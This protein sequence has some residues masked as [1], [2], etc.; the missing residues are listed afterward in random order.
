MK[1][2]FYSTYGDTLVIVSKFFNS[3]I[4][5]TVSSEKSYV[6]TDH[7]FNSLVEEGILLYIGDL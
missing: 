2:V 4:K 1:S 5:I 3:Q 7:V 6:V